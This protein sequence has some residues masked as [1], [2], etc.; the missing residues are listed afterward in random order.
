MTRLDTLIEG[1]TV[2]DGVSDEP[3]RLA[4]GIRGQKIAYVG[5]DL[6]GATAGARIDAEGLFLCPGFIDT[7]AST[8]LGYALPKAADHKLFQGVTTEITGNCGT[9]SGPVGPL[10]VD[11]MER[12]AED[13]GFTFNW[14]TLGE[15]LGRVE[16]YGL[17]FNVG[18]FVGHATLR[19][20]LVG[21]HQQVTEAEVGEMCAELDRA[22]SEGGL[23]F[24][25]GLVYAP[26]S[27]A[28]TREIIELAR[29]AGRHG[30]LYVSHIRDERED[31]I[32]R[33]H[34]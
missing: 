10:L 17:P 29:V 21:D 11:T 28:E 30:G 22:A 20:G 19:A 1:A 31:Q 6:A 8:G 16:D 18:T 32:G 23:G 2:F 26:G 24:S 4:V 5:E 34:V 25:T 14:R 7:H 33:A 27:F 12:L 15:W 9:S 13:I 3:Q